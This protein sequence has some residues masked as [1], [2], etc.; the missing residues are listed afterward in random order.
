MLKLGGVADSSAS[1]TANL[2]QLDM[3]PSV[4][5]AIASR[6]PVSF[7]YHGS[8]RTVHP[9]A[10]LLR[11]G[12]WYVLG[13]DV[14]HDAVRT[15][16][17][18]RIEGAVSVGAARSFER[19]EGF[20]PR[21][22]FP[23]DPKELGAHDQSATVRIDGSRAT[24]AV[25]ELGDDAVVRRLP[26]GAVEVHVPCSNRDA[27]RSWLLGWGAHAQLLAPADVLQEFLDWLRS[28]AGTS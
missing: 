8:P 13:H 16:R 20:D 3:L 15:Y 4:R 22:V 12:F 25:R 18:D 2:P 7:T 23:A 26:D 27:F 6:S 17:A 11:E 1:I 28:M 5:E 21:G 9:Y 24:F 14:G 19:P 10:L